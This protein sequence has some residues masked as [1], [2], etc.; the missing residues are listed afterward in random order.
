MNFP[1]YNLHEHSNE[2]EDH[3]E[4][5]LASENVLSGFQYAS[6]DS[7]NNN[8]IPGTA[9]E[10]VFSRFHYGS[11]DSRG[12]TWIPTNARDSFYAGENQVHFP[13][14]EALG[15]FAEQERFFNHQN[16]ATRDVDVPQTL[17]NT[18]QGLRETDLSLTP[19]REP[20]KRYASV[21]PI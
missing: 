13:P 11:Q 12:N 16:T 21:V 7:G 10:G 8:W 14:T 18:T 1:I 9:S 17:D 20:E 2:P 15:F 3:G 19:A 6:Q 4:L 5:Q